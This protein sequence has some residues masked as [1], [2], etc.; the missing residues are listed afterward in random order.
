MKIRGIIPDTILNTELNTHNSLA[1]YSL[2]PVESLHMYKNTALALLC[3]H[4]HLF[5]DTEVLVLE[6]LYKMCNYASCRV[7]H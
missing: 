6:L 1:N 3:L 5:L 2:S 7:Q 4:V